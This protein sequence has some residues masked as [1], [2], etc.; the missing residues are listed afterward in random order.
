MYNETHTPGAAMSTRRFFRRTMLTLA[1]TVASAS[2][3]DTLTGPA[4][5]PR[6]LPVAVPHA[7]ATAA[8]TIGLS[9]TGFGLCYPAHFFPAS[10]RGW[11]CYP[12]GYLSITNTGGG[13]LNWTSTKSAT[14]IKRSQ[15]S[16]TAPSYV[17]ISVDGT[18]LPR[19]TYHGWIKVWATGATN[20]PQT[21]SVTMQRY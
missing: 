1:C 17:K 18:G 19:G 14:W 8:P 16:G 3:S 20:S 21:V 11:W 13:T 6:A 10:V 5:A 2:C 15:T 9:R 7:L 4:S 12:Y